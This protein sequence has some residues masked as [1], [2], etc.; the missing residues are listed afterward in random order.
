MVKSVKR[1]FYRCKRLG[2][3]EAL[4]DRKVEA[5]II[6]ASFFVGALVAT[7][8]FARCV[9]YNPHLWGLK[10]G[11]I[12]LYFPFQIFFWVFRYQKAAPAAVGISL[13]LFLLIFLTPEILIFSL[14]KN[15]EPTTHGSARFAN[16]KEIGNMLLFPAKKEIWDSF[17]KAGTDKVY[18]VTLAGRP[19]RDLD[20]IVIGRDLYGHELYDLEPHPIALGAPTRSGKG[21]SVIIP[22]LLTW[23]SSV[24]VND[25]KGENWQIT[26]AY[27]RKMGQLCLKFAPTD[28]VSCH[29]NP[30]Q[31]IRK[32]TVYEYQDAM[33]IANIIIAPG[34]DKDGFFAPSGVNFLTGVILHVLYVVKD[35][36]C[37]SLADVLNFVKPAN[38]KGFDDEES[39]ALIEAAMKEMTK[40]YHNTT[41]DIN[42][43]HEI[44]GSV[45]KDAMGE[46]KPRI[47]P[48]AAR[49]GFDMLGR[50]GPERSGIISSAILNLQPFGFPTIMRN[51]E[52]SDF[53]IDDL[54]NHERPIS[55]YFVIPP[56]EL[57]NTAVLMRLIIT[58]IIY[59]H[60]RQMKIEDGRASY[61]HRLLLLIDE[62]PALG[63]IELLEKAMAYVAGYGIKPF[64]I[65][66]DINQL[67]SIYTKD[68]SILSNCRI[69]IFY[70]PNDDKTPGLIEKKL[71]KKTVMQ[72]SH[73]FSGIFS[74]FSKINYSESY[75]S[76][77]LMTVD[78]ILTMDNDETLIFVTGE[79]PIRGEKIRYYREE[80]YLERLRWGG[81]FQDTIDRV[82]HNYFEESNFEA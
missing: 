53:R 27:R 79:H 25:I 66:Q 44:Y 80:R 7:Q 3:K 24:I 64:I 81:K 26:S 2:I 23:K 55:L 54:M 40:A 45:V 77:S 22:T 65:Y 50:P 76:R 39:E 47:H 28:L 16:T 6:L 32:G 75:I 17:R 58:Q 52:D 41:A 31:E 14:S 33:A 69:S 46:E 19:E 43:F 38:F 56:S 68:N 63:K 18:S 73:S 20:G 51:T 9:Y 34:K 49:T 21:V 36:E 35:K 11:N 10:I 57:T 59:H 29:Y 67:A 70:T 12:H 42:L 30:L 15:E 74:V 4:N 48:I 5:I 1:F 8:I 60:T 78:E 37:A 71:G 13:S 62:F 61:R 72:K 82:E